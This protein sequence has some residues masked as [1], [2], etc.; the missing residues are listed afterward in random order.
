[1]YFSFFSGVPCLHWSRPLHL[2]VD[3]HRV[4]TVTAASTQA[5]N[6]HHVLPRGDRL[7]GF[8]V[9]CTPSLQLAPL[10]YRFRGSVSSLES[11]A[12]AVSVRSSGTQVSSTGLPSG[13][14]SPNVLVRAR[15]GGGGSAPAKL[16]LPQHTRTIATQ[17][18]DAQSTT[19][20]IV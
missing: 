14:G 10:T 13:S 9:V 17:T 19:S 20:T 11:C 3:V 12:S 8:Q 16:P 6:V 5:Q 4:S 7:R 1:M 2:A 15:G 18:D